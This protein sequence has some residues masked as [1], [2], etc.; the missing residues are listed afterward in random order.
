MKIDFERYK[1]LEVVSFEERD[2][3]WALEIQV[4]SNCKQPRIQFIYAAL[5]GVAPKSIHLITYRRRIQI[6]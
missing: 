6:A 1:Q 5:D 2:I 4:K 3:I